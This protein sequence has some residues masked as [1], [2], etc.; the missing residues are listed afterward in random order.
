VWY[1]ELL[2]KMEDHCEMGGN[3]PVSQHEG[4][5]RG[6]AWMGFRPR[7]R[8]SGRQR[9]QKFIGLVR[10]ELQWNCWETN[11]DVFQVQAGPRDQVQ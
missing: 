1:K 3:F 5:D 11:K 8:W 7:W 9:T 2:A 10:P 4:G 6:E